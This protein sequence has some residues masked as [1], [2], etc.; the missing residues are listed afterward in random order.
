MTL[1]TFCNNSTKFCSQK[2][3]FCSQFGWTETT[4]YRATA[5][6]EYVVGSKVTLNFGDREQATD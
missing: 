1:D 3:L 2:K 5:P 4:G 6:Q